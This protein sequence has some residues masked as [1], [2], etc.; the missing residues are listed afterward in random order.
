MSWCHE[1]FLLLSLS[2]LQSCTDIV[3]NEHDSICIPPL[4]LSL[5]LSLPLLQFFLAVISE[6]GY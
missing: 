5:F 4:S 2:G 6:R 1:I 3:A